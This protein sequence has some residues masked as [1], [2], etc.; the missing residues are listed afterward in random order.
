MRVLCI[1]LRKKNNGKDSKL[2]ILLK[3]LINSFGIK[4]KM[5][6]QGEDKMGRG[7]EGGDRI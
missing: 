3:W 7:K 1:G 5:G 4:E 6:R 2:S